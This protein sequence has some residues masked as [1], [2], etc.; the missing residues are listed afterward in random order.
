MFFFFTPTRLATRVTLYPATSQIGVR[1]AARPLRTFLPPSMRSKKSAPI[2]P[3]DARERF[4]PPDALFRRDKISA[5]EIEQFAQGKG[6]RVASE[7]N[8]RQRV[9]SSILLGEDVSFGYQLEAAPTPL[10]DT[11]AKNLYRQYWSRFK[12][13]LRGDTD[14][15]KV[16]GGH[17]LT[18]AEQT[19]KAQLDPKDPWFLNRKNFDSLFPVRTYGSKK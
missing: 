11:Q 3:L 9:P 4:H 14:W 15:S 8:K 12:L 6:V 17:S 18:E 7:K 1:T 13:S 5:V 19:A 10:F 16:A 2:N